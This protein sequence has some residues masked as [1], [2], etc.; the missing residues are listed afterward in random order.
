MLLPY[1]TVGKKLCVKWV[2]SIKKQGK[3]YLDDLRLLP[4]FQSAHLM[5]AFLSH[6]A[7]GENLW[8][9]ATVQW[10]I[11]SKKSPFS[12]KE[13]WFTHKVTCH[14]LFC[15]YV[16]FR[17]GLMWKWLYKKP[18][19]KPWGWL[20]LPAQKIWMT[21]CVLEWSMTIYK[22]QLYLHVL[23]DLLLLISQLTKGINDQTCTQHKHHFIVT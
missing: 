2:V 19:K 23:S 11:L 21:F 13:T 20:L 14:S 22:E 4:R 10:T 12:N 17:G 1:Y 9:D 6:E 5:D 7:K 18:P 16:P 3:K 15:F 8:S